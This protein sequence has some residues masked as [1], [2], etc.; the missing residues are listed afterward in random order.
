VVEDSEIGV[1]EDVK[2]GVVEKEKVG[3]VEGVTSQRHDFF[4]P[5]RKFAMRISVYEILQAIV[6]TRQL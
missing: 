6:S 3:V 2:V 4:A 1:V 5:S